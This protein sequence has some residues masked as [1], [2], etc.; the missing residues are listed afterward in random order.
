V[1]LLS[2]DHNTSIK[3]IEKDDRF[4]SHFKQKEDPSSRI[5]SKENVLF[6]ARRENRTPDV[7]KRIANGKE[8]PYHGIFY[9]R[10]GGK[11]DRPDGFG[12]GYHGKGT[13]KGRSA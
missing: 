7:L 9:W 5:F 8:N 13:R 2:P 11:A 4:S 12:S 3:S 6:A 1:D 10:A